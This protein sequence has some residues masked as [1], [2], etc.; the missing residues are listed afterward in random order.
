LLD[1]EKT[2]DTTTKTFLRSEIVPR[3]HEEGKKPRGRRIDEQRTGLAILS[4]RGGPRRTVVKLQK[5]GGSGGSARSPLSRVPGKATK[6]RK[7]RVGFAP[8]LVAGAP[9]GAD[10]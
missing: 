1:D 9:G 2:G 4:R 10:L 3:A 8:D 6:S 5:G 7:R